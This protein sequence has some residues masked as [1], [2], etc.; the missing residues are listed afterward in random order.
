[1][2]KDTKFSTGLRWAGVLGV[3]CARHEIMLGL[4]DLEKGEQY[5]YL[6]AC[7][8]NLLICGQI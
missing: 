1:M 3:I 4:G 7:F 5:V 8:A 2:Q 6:I